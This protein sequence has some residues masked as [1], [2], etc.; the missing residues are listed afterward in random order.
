MINDRR[1]SSR[2]IINMGAVLYF[3]APYVNDI[4]CNV[5]D[6]SEEGICFEL[7]PRYEKQFNIGDS[8]KFCIFDT[9]MKK[10]GIDNELIVGTATIKYINPMDKKIVV[11][12][13]AQSKGL[14]DYIKHKTIF[15]TIKSQEA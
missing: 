14:E 11:G 7:K 8:F 2:L 1:Y 3:D 4:S 9:T 6:I 13:R 15:Y 10:I 12:C 5:K